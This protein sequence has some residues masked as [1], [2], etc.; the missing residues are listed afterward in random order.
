MR[1]NH[2][3]GEEEKKQILL[4][5]LKIMGGIVMP[6][7]SKMPTYVAGVGRTGNLRGSG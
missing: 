6:L 1:V 5:L 4:T 7:A 3:E 2:D